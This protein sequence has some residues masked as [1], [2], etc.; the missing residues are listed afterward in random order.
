M[1]NIYNNSRESEIGTY[2][3]LG[4]R[5]GISDDG[6]DGVPTSEEIETRHERDSVLDAVD[7]FVNDPTSLD[8][9]GVYNP[10]NFRIRFQ[11]PNTPGESSIFE[12]EMDFFAT[13][14]NL[15]GKN[16]EVTDSR[17]YGPTREIPNG[18]SYSGDINIG[19]TLSQDFFLY[20]WFLQWMNSIVGETTSNISY[21]DNYV[22][23]ML[24][25][26]SVKSFDQDE[27]PIVFVVEDVYPKT[28]SQ[29]DLSQSRKSEIASFTINLSFR[30]WHYIALDKKVQI[31]PPPPPTDEE[32]NQ[33]YDEYL[34][35]TIGF[36]KQNELAERRE[37]EKNDDVLSR[38]NP[39]PD[40]QVVFGQEK[41][42]NGGIPAPLFDMTRALAR[43]ATEG[44]PRE[45]TEIEKLIRGIQ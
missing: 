10:N 38:I 27:S 23:R 39:R 35:K 4:G 17:I 15:P 16:I 41:F 37:F 2:N 45:L 11:R 18:V 29:I 12:R 19:I 21:Y 20:R 22:G 26:P 31:P 25:M 5:L 42:S 14:V 1:A 7:R 44:V 3:I 9:K 28:M 36:L 8:F 43:E 6:R 30:K 40:K 24:I 33:E 13:T 32:A 34:A